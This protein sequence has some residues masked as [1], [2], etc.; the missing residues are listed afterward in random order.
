MTTWRQIAQDMPA[1][2]RRE[3]LA[4]LLGHDADAP[5]VALLDQRLV[6]TPGD[7]VEREHVIPQWTG[8]D[9]TLYGV[10][11]RALTFRDRMEAERA[12]TIADAR[13]G[14]A[15]LDPWRLMAE[16]TARGI[17]KPRVTVDQLLGW[18]DAIV[19]DLYAAIHGLAPYPPARIAAELA[20]H[21]GGEAPEPRRGGGD[22][23]AVQPRPRRGRAPRG[24][25]RKPGAPGDGG[26][27]D[28][29]RGGAVGP[30]GGT[31][32]QP[33]RAARAG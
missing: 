26:A 27:G 32:E 1:E 8:S 12:A 6:A 3:L 17:V 33:A 9:G 14:K 10:V 18:N 20:R 19:R 23:D 28:G 30:D 29:D 5:P 13:T 15:E 11:I 24:D 25:A 2:A 4:A 7:A 21:A 22:P 31:G 16:E